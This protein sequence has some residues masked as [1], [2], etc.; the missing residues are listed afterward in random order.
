MIYENQFDRIRR[1]NKK[2]INF[3]AAKI[4][5]NNLVLKTQ[6]TKLHKKND[7]E[8]EQQ[9]KHIIA[10]SPKKVKPNYKKKL[11]QKIH[12]AKQKAKHERIEISVRQEMMKR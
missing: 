10:Q 2:S 6:K 7:H 4:Q 12:K 11:K 8:L 3:F 9:I 5:N 1:L